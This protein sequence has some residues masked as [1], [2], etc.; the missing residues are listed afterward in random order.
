MTIPRL[1]H[2]QLERVVASLRGLRLVAVD[3]AVLTGGADGREVDEWDYEY[4][5]EPTMGVQLR[6]DIDVAFTFTWGSSLGYHCLEAYD[7]GIYE[8]LAHVGEPGGPVWFPSA[9]TCAGSRCSAA[10]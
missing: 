8:F 7:R 3:Y 5:H 6:S 9:I 10:R 1:T 2:A 4:W